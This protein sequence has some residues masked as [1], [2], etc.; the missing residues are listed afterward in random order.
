MSNQIE[1]KPAYGHLIATLQREGAYPDYAFHMRP[2]ERLAAQIADHLVGRS[3]HDP[4]TL[5][6]V[7]EMV[8]E[9]RQ[10]VRT[11]KV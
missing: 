8:E 5:C 10:R 4:H 7:I 1:P 11:A 3:R 2:V 6:R 9:L